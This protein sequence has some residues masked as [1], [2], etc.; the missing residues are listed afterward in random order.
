[1]AADSA[2]TGQALER[3]RAYLRLSA[4]LHLHPGLRGKQDPSELV[5]QTLLQAY[6]ALDGLRGRTD[7]EQAVW[8]RQI[9]ARNLAHAVRDRGRQCRDVRREQSLH[10]ED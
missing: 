9:L 7:A 4:R 6:Q 3:F 5:Q 1:M 8:L 10:L 2:V